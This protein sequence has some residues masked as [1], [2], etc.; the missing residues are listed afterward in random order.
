M[1]TLLSG[2]TFSFFT[3]EEL[4]NVSVCE[5]VNPKTFDAQNVANPGGLYDPRLGPTER[6]AV[7]PTCSE[8]E[9][10]C[11]GH[12]GR[13]EL[14]VPCYNPLLMGQAHKLLQTQCLHCNALR[15]D[16]AVVE[17]YVARMTLICAGE[18]QRLEKLEMPPRGRKQKTS[19]AGVDEAKEGDDERRRQIAAFCAAV[20]ADAASGVLTSPKSGAH[21]RAERQRCAREFYGALR[22]AVRCETCGAAQRKIRKDGATKFFQ[23]PL[24]QRSARGDLALGIRPPKSA[25]A[26]A[27][28][29]KRPGLDDLASSDDDSSDDDQE[30]G[31]AFLQSQ[32]KRELFLTCSEVMKQ[33]MLLWKHDGLALDA[34]LGV[35]LCAKGAGDAGGYRKFFLEV[36]AVPPPRFRPA[37]LV[38]GV[39]AEHPQNVT[40][41]KVL[42]L[43]GEI[44]GLGVDGDEAKRKSGT[45]KANKL[46]ELWL[47]LQ[48]E[49]N[50][51]IDSSKSSNKDQP[52]GIKQLLERKEG[53]FRK[54]MMGKRVDFC[55]RSVISP[56]PFLGNG[57]IGLP[58]RFARE[59]SYPEP[60][61]PHNVELLRSMVVNG[62]ASWPGANWVE[63]KGGGR[64]RVD[65]SR[66]TSVK[67]RAALAKQLLT[68][69]GQRVGRHVLDGDCFLVNRQPSLHK[70]SIMAHVAKV[71]AADSLREH[72]TL[73]MHYAN[74]NAYNA[75]FDGDEINCHFPQ[76]ELCRAEAKL[77]AATHEQY[78]VPTDGKP[79]RGLIQDHVDC[80]VKLSM[81]DSFI[82]RDMFCQM[83]YETCRVVVGDASR[84]DVRIAGLRPAILK[85]RVL[86]TGRQLISLVLAH[87]TRRFAASAGRDD[88]VQ[89]FEGKAK[90]KAE[91]IGGFAGLD[92]QLVYVRKG[93]V[94]RG[95]LDKATVGASANGLVH[96]IYEL[97][98]AHAAAVLLD[99]ISRMFTLYLRYVEGH[100]CGI[101][102]L[103]LTEKA[104][105][106]R[107]A[108]VLKAEQTGLDA[109]KEFLAARRPAGV[110]DPTL[111]AATPRAATLAQRAELAA[112]LS[113]D[114]GGAALDGHMQGALAPAH[115]AIVKACLP[116]GLAT[117]FPKNSFALM[118]TTGAKG[119]IVNQ[120][121]VSCALGQQSLEGRRVPLMANGKALPCFE[122][123]DQS[124][125]AGGFITD[126]FLTGVRP[127]E[128][129]FHCMAGREG[130]VDTA[131]KTSRSG[132][133]QRCLVKHLEELTVCYDHTVRDAEGS[134]VQFLY[135]DDGLDVMKTHF[136]SGAKELKIL[137]DNHRAGASREGPDAANARAHEA[138]GAEVLAARR[139]YALEALEVGARVD[140]RQI[141]G[142]GRTR[143]DLKGSS[144]SLA[145]VVKARGGD[146]YDVKFDH[147]GSIMKKAPRTVAAG[148]GR[149]VEVLRLAAKQPLNARYA[150][151]RFGAV[152]D[153]LEA[154][155][156]DLDG[157]DAGSD[158]RAAVYGKY[159]RSLAAPG[160]AVG[161]LAA[162]SVGEPSTQ[163]T[164]NTFHLAGHGAG[165]VTLGIPR[166]REIIMT[167][168]DHIKTP[169]ITLPLTSR[170][171]AA[172]ARARTFADGL[173][174][175]CLLELADLK[176][177]IACRERVHLSKN[178][179]LR[180]EYVATFKLHE[181]AKIVA[182]FGPGLVPE[183]TQ[184]LCRK[185]E[186][187][188]RK[189]VKTMTA[190]PAKKLPMPTAAKPEA[191]AAN[192][193]ERGD[194]DDDDDDGDDADD[195]EQGTLKFGRK[196]EVDGY[197][198][199]DGGDDDEAVEAAADESDS[200]DE[201]HG[202]ASPAKAAAG[203]SPAGAKQAPKKA[204][205]AVGSKTVEVG[206][207]C[208]FDELR[209]RLAF[210]VVVD[211][212]AGAPR[213][214]LASMVEA[215][216][217]RT[218]V[219]EAKGV[220][221]A[222]LVPDRVVD[223]A[224]TGGVVVEG[225]NFEAIW[226]ETLGFADA[227]D[228]DNL[229]SNDISGILRTYGVEAARASIVREVMGVFGV[230]GIEVEPHHLSLI[231]D[232]MTF[233]GAY[234]AM[235]RTAMAQNSSPYLQ[236]SFETTADFLA[237]AA[238]AEG[239]ESL[240]SPSARI[241]VGQPVGV[242]TNHFDVVVPLK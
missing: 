215:A 206:C 126:R 104:E 95:V 214:S 151:W 106:A 85:P 156:D 22:A 138:L 94:L 149:A 134:V 2:T 185:L 189:L 236:M 57:E 201:E 218:V 17:Y 103:V 197:D 200:D 226:K 154:L 221:R 212:G 117:M 96:A 202:G 30:L 109:L 33:L 232:Y 198:D 169:Q 228:V 24:D 210:K 14:P 28:K 3:P 240:A 213:C 55:C 105:K 159:A 92:E 235:N 110:A 70:P 6:G 26:S 5:V 98:G 45:E 27:K 239:R 129:Y 25:H 166:L 58:V 152:S 241:V 102:D 118:V 143:A 20:R 100:T 179:L 19:G 211:V 131:V 147:D 114:G 50:N 173:N 144:W 31:G 65:L 97:Y 29:I 34:L 162:Q 175:V 32:E 181:D 178:R 135:G 180:R 163:M 196:R 182:H 137:G 203:R 67:K 4:R 184:G 23:Q 35:D 125:R 217:G 195:A 68:T 12:L 10:N 7:C 51:F 231:A 234:K 46:L 188:V 224:E 227:V 112:V 1:T 216:C 72:Q 164:L 130:L 140:A 171:D 88:F 83:A 136:L 158:I 108:L 230:Y 187:A 15:L 8:T 101:G 229:E 47:Q 79:L 153:K 191:A 190:P 63:L 87:V 123:Y 90:V 132:Y 237:K 170:D 127:Q 44:R 139:G 48:S 76:S 59:L 124:P 177:G 64:S 168:S 172:M 222:V 107:A 18:F 146:V 142:K 52:P 41:S 11:H 82:P 165:N 207:A 39:M 36:M 219:R 9:R 89:E 192:G 116:N 176:E 148:E 16:K 80:A 121:Q 21:A 133:L 40:L 119:S 174:K 38:G 161:A 111:A 145:T 199:D 128:Y 99:A 49:V 69:P 225:D 113:K 157:G 120:S 193:A 167:A 77:I 150:P 86:Y 155:L 233:N 209:D 66:I 160:E 37:Q 205:A 78:V 42:T 208:H 43:S 56:D 13:V 60:V 223:G 115:S 242:G 122:A 93:R 91:A 84:V 75:D 62:H 220:T 204:R 61:T 183:E 141:V 81:A 194:S 53:L 238:M 74:C 186:A 54:H 71:L 73:R